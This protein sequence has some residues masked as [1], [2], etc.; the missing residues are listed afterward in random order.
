VVLI[1]GLNCPMAIRPVG[2]KHQLVAPLYVH[3]MMKG[4]VWDEKISIM[5]S[6]IAGSVDIGELEP[7]ASQLVHL[8]F[9]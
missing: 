4:E 1:P 5:S 3:G 8:E 2:E 6:A 7:T 9:V